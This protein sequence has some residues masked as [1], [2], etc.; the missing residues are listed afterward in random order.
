MTRALRHERPLG[1]PFRLGSLL[2]VKGSASVEFVLWLPI[3]LY[4]L[5]NVVDLS[6]Y[7]YKRMEVEVSAHAAVQ[8]AW[9]TCNST[10]LLPTKNCAG[11]LT[12]MQTAAQSTQLGTAVSLPAANVAESFLCSNGSGVRALV[13]PTG[14]VDGSTT[15]LPTGPSTCATVI[16][17]STIAPGDY[18]SATTTYTYTP[19][20]GAAT[21]SSLLGT[22]ISKT[23][24]LRLN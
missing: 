1:R 14:E 7:T 6:I 20:F 24:W 15:K 17:G 9:H 5:F 8:A 4:P 19:I 11:V 12:V 3:V 22:T 18:I 16:T 13:K 10:N 23:A 21:V 2:D